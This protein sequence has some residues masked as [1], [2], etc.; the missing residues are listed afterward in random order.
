LNRGPRDWIAESLSG[1][2]TRWRVGGPPSASA[3]AVTPPVEPKHRP[4]PAQ[5][6]TEKYA[7]WIKTDAFVREFGMRGH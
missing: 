4:F 7:N 1:P 2:L 3:D 5:G 6:G